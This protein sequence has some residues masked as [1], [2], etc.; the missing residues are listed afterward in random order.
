MRAI[1]I[2]INYVLRSPVALTCVVEDSGAGPCLL[3]SFDLGTAAMSLPGRILDLAR[4]LER[5]LARLA[6]DVVVVRRADTAPTG[7][8]AGA[9]KER[10]FIEGALTLAVQQT[11]TRIEVRSGRD[12]GVL[13]GVS[14]QEAE[15]MGAD[16]DPERAAAAA[17]AL[18]AL[19]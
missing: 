14:K 9:V 8:R 19:L 15:A 4:Q 18:S 5:Q 1:G 2:E 13:Q 16:L 10:M 12:V 7:R 17:A 3:E 11:G 6:P